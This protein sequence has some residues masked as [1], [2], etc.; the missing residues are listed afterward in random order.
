MRVAENGLCKISDRYFQDFS[1]PRHVFNKQE[2]RP[3]FLAIRDVKGIVW[4][5]PLSSQVEKY[6]AKIKSDEEK[7]GKCIFHHIARVKG[8][9]NAFLIGNSIPVTEEYILGPFT[10]AGIP[11]VIENKADIKEIRSKLRRYLA[12]VRQGKLHPAV[13]ILSIEQKLLNKKDNAEYIV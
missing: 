11:F 12:L 4:L 10:M 13:D 5:V 7:H 3:Y 9:E 2:N 1:S 6:R 8:S